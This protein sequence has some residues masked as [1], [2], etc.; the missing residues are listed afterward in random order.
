MQLLNAP[1]SSAHSN[2]APVAGVAVNVNVGVLSLV[3]LAGD[4]VIVVSG[5]QLTVV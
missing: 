3:G 2:V 4:D 5:A 1:L